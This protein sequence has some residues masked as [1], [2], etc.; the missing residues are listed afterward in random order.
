MQARSIPIRKEDEVKI[1]RGTNKGRDGKVIQVY[2]KKWVIHIERITREKANG[3]TVAIDPRLHL[4]DILIIATKTSSKMKS[5][6]S[7]WICLLKEMKF[8]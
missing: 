8:Q 7:L 4:L 1:V 6:L 5:K 3:S 2:R